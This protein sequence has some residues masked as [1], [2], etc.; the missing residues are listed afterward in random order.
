MVLNI[1][2]SRPLLLRCRNHSLGLPGRNW[3]DEA[4]APLTFQIIPPMMELFRTVRSDCQAGLRLVTKKF[5]PD[6]LDPGFVRGH[7]P[8]QGILQHEDES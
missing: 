5:T 4:C 6:V 3:K 2:R 8:E 7:C 1:S